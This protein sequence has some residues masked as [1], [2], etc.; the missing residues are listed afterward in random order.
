MKL[1]FD[2]R[3]KEFEARHLCNSFVATAII[4]AGVVGAGGNGTAGVVIV[5]NYF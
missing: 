5:T 3:F 2:G 1:D 4:G